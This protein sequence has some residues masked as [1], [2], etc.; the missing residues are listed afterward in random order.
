LLIRLVGGVLSLGV[1]SAPRPASAAA[2]PVRLTLSDCREL[3]G[4]EVERLFQA[5]LDAGT[6]PA[7]DNDVTDVRILCSGARASVKVLDRLSRKTV[8][9]SFELSLFVGPARNRLVALGAAELVLASWAELSTNPRP[10][11]EPEGAPP[12]DEARSSAKRTVGVKLQAAGSELTVTRLDGVPPVVPQPAATAPVVP[13]PDAAPATPA[14]ERPYFAPS[15][16]AAPPVPRRRVVPRTRVL[17]LLSMRAFFEADGT[18]R[19]GGVRAGSEP[20]RYVSWA[21]DALVERG[22]LLNYD[23]DSMTLGGWVLAFYR[24]EPLSF[25]LGFGLRGGAVSSSPEAG[26][27]LTG[28]SSIAP[29]GWPLA[30]GTV[31]IHAGPIAIDLSGEGGYAVLPLR[32]N[33][34]PALAGS[35]YSLQL[36]VGFLFPAPENATSPPPAIGGEGAEGASGTP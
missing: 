26:S 36:G 15:R 21:A 14:N 32:G 10:R 18:L 34:H 28:R 4:A 30:A 19:G 6:P 13:A 1:V 8:E 35:W 24:I 33:E 5:E 2:P 31:T 25:R 23:V 17:A 3:D 9:R 20:Y 16:P 11:A 29:W 12:S 27:G 22:K 7:A